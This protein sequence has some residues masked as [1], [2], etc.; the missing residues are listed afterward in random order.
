LNRDRDSLAL[1]D[2]RY[3]TRKDGQDLRDLGRRPHPSGKGIEGLGLSGPGDPG[4]ELSV[5]LASK[6]LLADQ[7]PLVSG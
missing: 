1:S 6:L 2:P 5:Q 3:V 7:L 4:V